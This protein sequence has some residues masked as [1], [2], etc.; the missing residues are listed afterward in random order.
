[1]TQSVGFVPTMGYLHE[2][3]CML[4]R[5]SKQ[6]NDITIVSIFVNPLQFG[7][8][9]DL[10]NYP[11]DIERDKN[12]LEAEGVELL[13]LPKDDDIY[14]NKI[15]GMVTTVAVDE[16][17]SSRACG[18]FRQGHFEGVATIVLKLFNIV[19]PNRAYFGLKD[20]QQFVLIQRMIHDL[21]LKVTLHGL[22]TH[23]EPDGLAMSSRN[24]YLT[25][26]DRVLAPMINK[27][28]H[29]ILPLLREGGSIADGRGIFESRLTDLSS[30]FRVQY[31]ECYDR[32]FNPVT[33]IIEGERVLVT[34]VYLGDV[35]LIDNS[36]F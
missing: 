22:P 8:T 2:G 5:A 18:T 27:T 6:E 32:D 28:L 25:E 4:I 10:V 13:F 7:P 21:N 30:R 35:R 9:E 3:H 29:E 26:Q 20:Y 14:P 12:R 31:L 33:T 16:A 17:F 36:L 34:A 19:E 24:T 23:R 15:S 1:M 11:R